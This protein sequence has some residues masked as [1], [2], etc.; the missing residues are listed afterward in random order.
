[1][2]KLFEDLFKLR[3]EVDEKDELVAD[4]NAQIQI[5]Q[6][7][8]NTLSSELEILKHLRPQQG[9]NAGIKKDKKEGDGSQKNKKDKIF[10]DK[11]VVKPIRGGNLYYNM[12]QVIYNIRWRKCEE[13]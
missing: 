11:H 3:G 5:L 6:V 7:G 13:F 10:F 1:M 9:Q 12:Q 8:L 2:K 4:K